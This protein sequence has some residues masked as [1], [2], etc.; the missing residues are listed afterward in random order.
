M[1]L[2]N[3]KKPGPKGQNGPPGRPRG[4]KAPKKP[5]GTWAKGPNWATREA[6]GPQGATPEAP[7]GFKKAAILDSRVLLF[8]WGLKIEPFLVPKGQIGPLSPEG[9]KV[10]PQKPPRA[11]AA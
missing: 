7:K 11:Q 2:R 9:P 3:P 8:S 5:Q 4:P 1:S 6:Q 10:P